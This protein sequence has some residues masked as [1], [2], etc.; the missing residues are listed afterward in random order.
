MK[1]KNKYIYLSNTLLNINLNLA[2]LILN[3]LNF[4]LLFIHKLISGLYLFRIII[5]KLN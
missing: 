5:I 2:N 4:Y 1:K 3:F